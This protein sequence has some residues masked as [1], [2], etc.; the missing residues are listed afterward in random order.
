ML[1]VGA[2]V[3]MAIVCGAIIESGWFAGVLEDHAERFFWAG[4]VTGLL[5]VFVFAAAAAPGGSDDLK[6]IRRVTVLTRIGLILFVIAPS[7]C[8]IGM[9]AD[10]YRLLV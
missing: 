10:F 7:L 4:T 9:V 1:F 5:M 6:V 3:V 2:A 8:L